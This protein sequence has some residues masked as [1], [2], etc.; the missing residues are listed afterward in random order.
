MRKHTP[1]LRKIFQHFCAQNKT[2]EAGSNLEGH[3]FATTSRGATMDLAEFHLMADKAR[4]FTPKFNKDELA[5]V[6][7]S[8]QDGATSSHGA[9]G[10]DSELVF[11]EVSLFML[12]CLASAG[13]EIA[14]SVFF[15]APSLDSH[16]APQFLQVMVCIAVYFDPCPFSPMAWRMDRFVDKHLL[17]ALALN[18]LKF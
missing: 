11:S 1:K 16:P 4:L 2:A 6:F 14:D 15:F 10:D 18:H 12:H 9:T 3:H 7:V 5:S 8:M 17:P 13:H